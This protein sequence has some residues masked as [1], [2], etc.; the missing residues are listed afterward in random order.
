LIPI[1]DFVQIG[2]ALTKIENNQFSLIS[3]G[4][5]TTHNNKSITH[6]IGITGGPG[7]GKS[8]FINQFVKVAL[9]NNL[10]VA[11]IAIDP[12]S[13]IHGGTFLGDRIRL[14]P[15][16]PSRGVFIR[17]VSS[18]HSIG[19]IPKTVE[20]MTSFL[21]SIGFNLILI[22]TVGIGQLESEI[23]KYVQKVVV[24]PNKNEDDWIQ[25]FKNESYLISDL[26]Y[27]NE[28]EMDCCEKIAESIRSYIEIKHKQN[29]FKPECIVGNAK[30][31]TGVNEAFNKLIGA[32]RK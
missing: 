27:L 31:G 9:S 3:Q 29:T 19:G 21:S 16:Y 28:F 15:D 4:K 24:I 14:D 10:T 5:T 6:V 17:S 13:G 30:N 26:F 2:K 32:H 20:F 18:N 23:K 22:E 12:T 7:V 11:V 8:T 1:D 25:V